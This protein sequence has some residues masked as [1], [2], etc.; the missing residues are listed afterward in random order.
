MITDKNSVI[1][2]KTETDGSAIVTVDSESRIT[3]ADFTIR[4]PGIYAARRRTNIPTT[5]IF[6]KRSFIVKTL[7]KQRNSG[8]IR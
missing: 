8:L 6:P 1:K 4:L 7:P 3:K 2:I 5:R